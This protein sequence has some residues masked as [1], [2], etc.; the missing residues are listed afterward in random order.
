MLVPDSVTQ[1]GKHFGEDSFDVIVSTMALGEFP[2]EYLEYILRDC[3]RILRPGGRLM[4]ADEV[5]PDAWLARSIYW[6]GL[7]LSWIPQF[8][9]LRRVLVPVA[10]LRGII[11]QAGFHIQDVNTWV[12][13]SFQL[14]FAEK[15]PAQE[16]S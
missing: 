13:S 9:L 2:R 12:A 8:L 10:D 5:L 7:A 3:I 14:V 1:L 16:T 15:E 4:I 11:R 6:I